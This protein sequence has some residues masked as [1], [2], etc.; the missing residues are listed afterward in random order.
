M[1][2][3]AGVASLPMYLSGQSRGD[4]AALWSLA[5]DALRAMEI[6]APEALGEPDDLSAHWR[7]PDLL[8]SQ[9][10]A[11]PYRDG[12][13]G[14]VQLL[15][16][17]DFGLEACPPGYYR[18]ALVARAEDRRSL[19]P[20]LT[21]GRIAIN[22]RDSQSGSVVLQ[23]LD[24]DL[25]GALVTGAHLR[26]IEA[27]AAGRADLAAIDANTWRHA[28][29]HEAPARGLRVCG[30][31]KPTPGLPL[32][33]APGQPADSIRAALGHAVA[34]MP[35]DLAARLGIVGWVALPEALYA[36]GSAF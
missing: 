16:A 29:R 32:I 27:V 9:T 23:R 21:S 4:W 19:D 8:L 17:F 35:G 3:A 20:L 30:W 34:A 24:A 12:L 25:R 15:G 28:L 18:S 2:R 11:K 22:G 36:D 10:C 13:R 26:S 14:R 6:D 5:R 7:A 31:T 1:R 33:T